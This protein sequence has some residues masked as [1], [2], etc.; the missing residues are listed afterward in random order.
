MGRWGRK[1]WDQKDTWG[2]WSSGNR[3]L[4]PEGGRPRRTRVRPPLALLRQFFAMTDHDRQFPRV[5]HSTT[6]EA[7]GTFAVSQNG[8]HVAASALS[9]ARPPPVRSVR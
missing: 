4:P 2:A 6:G 1:I 5:G 9:G 7:G 3:R 8:R